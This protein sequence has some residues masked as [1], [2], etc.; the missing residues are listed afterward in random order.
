[1]P[2]VMVT[3]FPAMEQAPP[4][5]AVIVAV[6]LAFVVAVT[7]NELPYAAVT[8]APVKDTVGAVG[9]VEAKEKTTT[10][11]NGGTGAYA[12]VP[13]ATKARLPEAG[14]GTLLMVAKVDVLINFRLALLCTTPKNAVEL[15]GVNEFV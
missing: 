13:P 3:V 7:A 11:F 8:G 2:L 6:V 14:M 10:S 15:S 9:E 4:A 12:T 5:L 1:M